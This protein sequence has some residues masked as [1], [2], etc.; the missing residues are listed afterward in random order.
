MV[1]P[2]PCSGGLARDLTRY[3]VLVHANDARSRTPRAIWLF[4]KHGWSSSVYRCS[5]GCRIPHTVVY[6]HLHTTVQARYCQVHVSYRT[7]RG[8]RPR[9]PIRF[10]LGSDTDT[11]DSRSGFRL[12]VSFCPLVTGT[13]SCGLPS[14]LSFPGSRLTLYSGVFR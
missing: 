12:P 2:I 1:L 4:G 13:P 7:I 10:P 9:G 6:L 3:S 14:P 8:A 11:S 5:I